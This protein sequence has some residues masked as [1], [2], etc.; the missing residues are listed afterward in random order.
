M[1]M[2]RIVHYPDLVRPG[3]GRFDEW[4]DANE[5]FV[6]YPS[7]ELAEK[8]L[9]KQYP[10]RTPAEIMAYAQKRVESVFSS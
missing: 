7:R 4:D 6:D 1:I 8:A 3:A 2:F 9:A 5:C 10:G